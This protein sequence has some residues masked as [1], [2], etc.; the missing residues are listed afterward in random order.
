MNNNNDAPQQFL[1]VMDSWL[2]KKVPEETRNCLRT[3]L[4]TIVGTEDNE[5]VTVRLVGSPVDGSQ[6]LKRI[7]VS[8]MCDKGNIVVV[9]Y[10]NNNLTNAFILFNLNA[11]LKTGEISTDNIPTITNMEMD[12]LL[13]W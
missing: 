6:D 3:K 10:T 4:G 7:R 12:N 5:T 9:A 2:K 13:K 8:G 1:A 11:T